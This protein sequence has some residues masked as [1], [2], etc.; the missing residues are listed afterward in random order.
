MPLSRSAGLFNLAAFNR[1]VFSAV[2]AGIL[3]G[4]LLTGVQQ[5]QVSKIILQAE[6][7]E[8]AADAAKAAAMQ[9]AAPRVPPAHG[10]PGHDH[11]HD[12]AAPA[13]EAGHAA[14]E[15]AGEAQA[16]EAHEHAGWQPTNGAERI[17]FTVVANVSV[18]SSF[19][20]VLC[21]I[22]CMGGQAAGWRV[23]LLWGLA[24]YA[25]FFLAPSL[26]LPPEVP[27]TASAPLHERQL[28]WALTA[29]LTAGGLGL[30]CFARG[31]PLKA[32]GLALLAAPHLV[33]A[34]QPEVHA[35]AAPEELARAFIYATAMA[36]A[37]FW[38]ALGTLTGFFYKRFA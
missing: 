27:G 7:Y 37:L 12:H 35:S 29:A 3:A 25:V 13:A 15:H 4:L 17:F 11:L 6:V 21:A 26:G 28:W 14:H 8:E 16:D 20:L 9:Q 33:G 2:T 32:L 24:G 23:G 34:P 31:W 1:I 10:Q 38:L 5:L 36:N 30:L 18:A 22:Y 19:G